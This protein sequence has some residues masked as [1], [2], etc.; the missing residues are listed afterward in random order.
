[1]TD[2][3]AAIAARVLELDA[4]VQRLY[5]EFETPSYDTNVD[6]AIRRMRWIA[7]RDERDSLYS[8]AAPV[9]ATALLAAYE[10]EQALVAAMRGLARSN[11]HSNGGVLMDAIEGD[12]PAY[13]A[14]ALYYLPGQRALY[15]AIRAIVTA[16]EGATE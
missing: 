8:T 6:I 15:H 10:Q 7:A 5:A 1:M 9:L 2:E 3:T 14:E 13:R 16:R 12:Q 11:A 4:N